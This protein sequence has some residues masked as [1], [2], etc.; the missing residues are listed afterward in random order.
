M[1]HVKITVMCSRGSML[2]FINEI[3]R[4]KFLKRKNNKAVSVD[5]KTLK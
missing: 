4:G 3:N 1:F 2:P 5:P